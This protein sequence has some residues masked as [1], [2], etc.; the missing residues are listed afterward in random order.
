MEGTPGPPGPAGDG[1][2]AGVAG[3]PGLSGLKEPSAILFTLMI[4]NWSNIQPLF[5]QIQDVNP[6]RTLSLLS[7]PIPNIKELDIWCKNILETQ[8]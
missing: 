2:P 5:I 7:G 8:S 1:G 3:I 6:V 4:S